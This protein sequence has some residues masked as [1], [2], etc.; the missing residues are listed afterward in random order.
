MQIETISLDCIK[1]YAQNAKKHP[2]Y[3]IEQ[4][5]AS[6]LSFGN[7]DP[8]AI[9]ENNVIIE[10][11]GRY[12]ALKA[13][14][15]HEVPVIK[16]HHLSEDQKRAYI[17]AHNKITLNTDFDLTILKD[18]LTNILDIDMT[19]FGFSV[20]LLSQP[21]TPDEELKETEDSAKEDLTIQV[22]D[23]YQCGNHRV[24]CGDSTNPDHLRKL[25]EEQTID[26]YV[27]DPPYNVAYEGKTKD[28][29]TIQNDQME[30]SAFQDF[31]TDA[32]QTVDPFLKP[33]GAFYI[34]HADSERLNFS[35]ALKRTGWLEKQTLIWAKDTFVLGRQDYQW[36]H[37]PCLYGWKPGSGHYFIS[38]FSQS[39]ILENSLETKSK[40]ELIALIKSYQANQPTSILRVNRP[41]R[42]EDHPTMKP[43]A[44]LERLIR[45]SSK[46]GENI[47]D[48]FAGSGSTLLACERLG[49]TCYALELDP[50]YVAVILKRFE[51]ATG[52]KPIKLTSDDSIRK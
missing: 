24:L 50:K 42:N 4:I 21:L 1:P 13:L 29:L 12:L 23:L 30:A 34:W 8:I 6:I 11:H 31:L 19:P 33:G 51:E 22:G 39:T 10:G 46:Q 5:K 27:T 37:E 3:Q 7:N 48:S 43:I 44:L 41:T 49:R 14:G 2:Q 28:A 38:E 35:Q 9:D 32:F 52:I 20:N 45:S 25:V 36:Q 26:L 17:L 47:L 16:L 40:Q 18:E 15:Y